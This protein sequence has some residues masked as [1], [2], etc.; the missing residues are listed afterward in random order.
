MSIPTRFRVERGYL[1][2]EWEQG[3]TVREATAS[4]RFLAAQVAEMNA[5]IGRL[6]QELEYAQEAYRHVQRP[7]PYQIGQ[8]FTRIGNLQYLLEIRKVLHEYPDMVIEVGLPPGWSPP[9]PAGES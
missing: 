3:S 1:H 4:E 8:V 5:T 6:R 9:Q 2:E 7:E